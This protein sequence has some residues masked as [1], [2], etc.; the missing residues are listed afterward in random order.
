MKTYRRHL[1]MAAFHA[2]AMAATIWL[3]YSGQ[4]TWVSPF[5]IGV[6]AAVNFLGML[7]RLEKAF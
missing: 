7:D 3:Y 4:C 2:S 6:Y 5:W 1:L